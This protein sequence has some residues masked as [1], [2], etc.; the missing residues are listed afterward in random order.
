M[1]TA[2]IIR[3]A[4]CAAVLALMVPAPASAQIGGF[5]KRKLKEKIAQTVVEGVTGSQAAGTPV[6]TASGAEQTGSAPGPVASAPRARK[7]AP[8]AAA[9]PSIFSETT[10][11]MTAEL[12]DRFEKG[13]AAE[14]AER[15]AIVPQLARLLSNHDYDKCLHERVAATPAGQKAQREYLAALRTGK[16]EVYQGAM[17]KYQTELERIGEPVCGL[18]PKKAEPV[19]RELE[20]RPEKAALQAAGL[21]LYQY[22]VLK[23]RIIPFCA[24]AG[25]AEAAGEFARV[26]D[27]GASYVYTQ[28]EVAALRPRCARLAPALKD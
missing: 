9:K 1:S 19:R 25:T 3:W 14:K 10:L 13:V 11:E 8:G 27:R 20:E 28:G 7:G 26:R 2:R 23:E 6:D 17:E 5:L 18:S 15:K 22:A 24:L 21:E 4:A 12:L 16:P